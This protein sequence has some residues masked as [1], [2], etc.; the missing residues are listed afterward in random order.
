MKQ[1]WKKTLWRFDRAYS[2]NSAWKPALWVAGSLLFFVLVFWLLGLL[3]YLTPYGYNKP[4]GTPRIVETLSLLLS[5]GSYPRASVLPYLFQAVVSLFG[6]VFFTAFLIATFNRVLANR[7]DNYRN[8]VSRYY[9]DN[10]I[11]IL[12]GGNQALRIINSIASKQ[13]YQGK[14]VVVLSARNTQTVREQLLPYLSPDAQKMVL[15]FYFG[16]YNME[17]LLTFLYSARKMSLGRIHSMWSV[18]K[19]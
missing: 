13:E 10:H 12:G 1:F 6:A 14:D 4:Y 3:W 8:G 16:S 2:A 18:G 15:T 5:P 19:R 17:L 9:F 7:V 11:L